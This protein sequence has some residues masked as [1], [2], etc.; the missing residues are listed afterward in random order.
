MVKY[1]NILLPIIPV[2]HLSNPK[3]NQAQPILESALNH[4][5][6]AFEWHIPAISPAEWNPANE[7][8]PGDERLRCTGLPGIPIRCV[9][10]LYPRRIVRIRFWTRCPHFASRAGRKRISEPV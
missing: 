8:P 4:P 9:P 5:T 10:G 2:F 1:R 7:K 3:A 6:Q